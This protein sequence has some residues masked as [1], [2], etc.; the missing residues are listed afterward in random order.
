MDV[1]GYTL[2][3]VQHICSLPEVLIN[4]G[5]C[6]VYYSLLIQIWETKTTVLWKGDSSWLCHLTLKNMKLMLVLR[7]SGSFKYL[8]IL[9][10]PLYDGL[11]FWK[12]KWQFGAG[13]GQ[14]VWKTFIWR[15]KN[16]HFSI[17]NV[18]FFAQRYE[19]YA[20]SQFFIVRLCVCVN[21]S[22]H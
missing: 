9:W 13:S 10:F 6:Y 5:N 19:R 4:Q 14:I 18:A 7:K 16:G 8:F 15:I 22:V 3:G 12:F 21:V 20:Y 1:A 17:F 11:G 2:K